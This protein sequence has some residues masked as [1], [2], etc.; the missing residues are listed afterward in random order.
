MG[1]DGRNSFLSISASTAKKSA[2]LIPARSPF[3]TTVLV[4]TIGQEIGLLFC[5]YARFVTIFKIKI[6]SN[7]LG[8]GVNPNSEVPKT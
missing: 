4:L 1:D 2:E 5:L 8:W 3:G 6:F 7:I